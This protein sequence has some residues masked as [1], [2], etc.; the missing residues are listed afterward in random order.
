M[1][2]F[3]VTSWLLG[4]EDRSGDQTQIHDA[5]RVVTRCLLAEE[6]GGG[7]QMP[8]DVTNYNDIDWSDRA[9]TQDLPRRR[10]RRCQQMQHPP[11]YHLDYYS[12]IYPVH[13]V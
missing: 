5:C 10:M 13:C 2:G 7:R 12:A 9:R 11:V 8:R 4:A 3:W 6:G 1:E